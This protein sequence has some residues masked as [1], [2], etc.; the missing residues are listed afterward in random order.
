VRDLQQFFLNPDQNNHLLSQV[1]ALAF[2][3]RSGFFICDVNKNI[4]NKFVYQ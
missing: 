1:S 3:L 4:K 2:A